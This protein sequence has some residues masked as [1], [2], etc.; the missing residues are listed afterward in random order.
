MI[1][2]IK[3]AKA[4]L[5]EMRQLKAAS[6][7]MTDVDG[8]VKLL[9]CEPTT[10]RS[11]LLDSGASHPFRTASEGEVTRPRESKSSSEM[12]RR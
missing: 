7:S 12:V 10:Q 6:L 8:M 2:L 9:G 5:K 3:E 4:T 11:G 1:S